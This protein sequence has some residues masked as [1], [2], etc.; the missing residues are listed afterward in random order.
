MAFGG[1]VCDLVTN[2][3]MSSSSSSRPHS[4]RASRVTV[5]YH[6]PSR[7]SIAEYNQLLSQ[8]NVHAA[9]AATYKDPFVPHRQ[10]PPPPSPLSSPSPSVPFTSTASSAFL[11]TRS[12]SL[13]TPQYHQP[14]QQQQQQASGSTQPTPTPIA[15][16][17]PR[18][19][20]SLQK[21][22]RPRK[23]SLPSSSTSPPVVPQSSSLAG[24]F[25][26]SREPTLTAAD[27]HAPSSSSTPDQHDHPF[28]GMA[29][30]PRPSRANTGT[31]D[32][33][34]PTQSA[35]AQR[36][37]SQPA[38]AT[39]DQPFYADPAENI[40]SGYP[41]G[42]TTPPTAYTSSTF[43]AGTGLQSSS[44]LAAAAG[45]SRAGTGS[46]GTKGRKGMLGFMPS[47]LNSSKRIEISTPYDPVH[48][49]HVGFNSS[50]GEFTGLP[51]E[52]QQL[53]QD[54]GISRSDQEKNPQAVMEIVKFYQEGHGDPWDKI[55]FGA[56]ASE[57]APD[58]FASPVR[59]CV[60]VLSCI[61]DVHL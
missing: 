55:G 59:A 11:P 42:T 31:L 56:G 30:P 34:F 25:S 21:P 12:A 18:V 17:P 53:L 24:Y 3:R 46:A 20:N 51:K 28:P 1:R 8:A 27:A 49:T 58:E 4:K 48:L 23:Q 39:Y 2:A 54:S 14:Q 29:A 22:Q 43:S 33:I 32:G 7:E 26:L 50:T 52:W 9:Q 40:P 47:F 45:R 36:R 16:S 19:R 61:V 57:P 41:S 6:R 13:Q 5:E 60:S 38:P 37:L 10:A 44:T 15:P 35:L